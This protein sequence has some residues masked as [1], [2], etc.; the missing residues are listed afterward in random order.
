MPETERSRLAEAQAALDA[1]DAAHQIA[2]VDPGM[3]SMRFHRSERQ[4]AKSVK[5]HL[6]TIRRETAERDRLV[7]AV[8][9]ARAAERLGS[10]PNDPVPVSELAGAS[11]VLE[12]TQHGARW[13]R[14]K[15]VNAKTVTCHAPEPGFDEPR[16]P[17]ERIVATRREGDTT[18]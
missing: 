10:L 2:P 3:Q 17:H 15:R 14:V 1:W 16:V 18:P 12:R 5:A 4:H 9:K 6:S 13:H 8:S 11:W 7:S